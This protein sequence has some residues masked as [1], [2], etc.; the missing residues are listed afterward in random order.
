[1][2]SFNKI[3][4][5]G[6]Y[7]MSWCS[8]VSERF[9][10]HGSIQSRRILHAKASEYLKPQKIVIISFLKGGSASLKDWAW[11]FHV[12]LPW[13]QLILGKYGEIDKNSEL[14]N[15]LHAVSLWEHQ[16]A[17]KSYSHI[18]LLIIWLLQASYW[19][20]NIQVS[21]NW[22]AQRNYYSFRPQRTE[23]ISLF[24]CQKSSRDCLCEPDGV[25]TG[26]MGNNWT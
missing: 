25:F 16:M 6:S 15:F 2:L 1:M 4:W 9:F 5:N 11:L 20:I 26:G 17:A 3:A 8:F 10:S 24:L 23:I 22:A 18:H 19:Q 21:T 7:L 13:L 14:N 12:E